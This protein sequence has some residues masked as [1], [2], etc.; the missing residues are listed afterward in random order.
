MN[1]LYD[2][3]TLE[4]LKAER[5][6]IDAEIERRVAIFGL[7]VVVIETP[8]MP[9]DTIDFFSG[10]HRVRVTGLQAAEEHFS[11]PW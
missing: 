9:P 6:K 10:P 7:E 8:S 11:T 2:I 3:M 5:A 1:D 4:Q